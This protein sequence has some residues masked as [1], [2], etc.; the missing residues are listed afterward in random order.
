MT[1]TRSFQNAYEVTDLTQELNLIPNRWGLIGELGIFSEQSVAQN[2]ITLE[3]NNKT[4]SVIPDQVRGARNN[5]NKDDTRKIASFVLT[6]HP[7]DDYISPQDINGRRAYGQADQAATEA[8]VMARKLERI[9]MNHAITLEA[10]RAY[11]ITTGRQF[12]PN[13]TVDTDFYSLFGIT[14]KEVDFVLGT[15]TT[16][17]IEKSEEVIAHIQ[18]NI[19]SGEVAG[20]FVGLASP[21]FFSKLIK[22]AGVR[23][24][25]RYYNSTQ[26]P[27]RERLG[28]GRFRTFYH[29]GI[30]WREYRGAYN[31]QKLIPAGEAYV[32]PL[33]TTDMAVTYF[34][35]ANKFGY[36]NTL[37]EQN[38]VWTYRDPMDEK[39]TLQTEQNLV[40]V[41]RRPAAIV[42][43]TTS[44]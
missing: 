31:G 30:M 6:H 18:D 21:E 24:A 15:S 13:G 17:V 36:L 5:V 25:Y 37:G 29:G 28:V 38:Y 8:E 41:L 19:L 3:L 43:C 7:L 23:D 20:D 42:K 40:N 44:N 16:E 33:N 14:R 26:E 12:A 9:R 22:Q 34:G 35:P 2:N 11:T 27:N 1:I 39:I 32:L 10:A 4:I